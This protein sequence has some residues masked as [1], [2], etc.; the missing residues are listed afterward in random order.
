MVFYLVIFIPVPLASVSIIYYHVVQESR[1]NWPDISRA[2][3]LIVDIKDP[4]KY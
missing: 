2:L 3:Q 4:E 1:T